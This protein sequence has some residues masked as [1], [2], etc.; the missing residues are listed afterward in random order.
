MNEFFLYLLSSNFHALIF[1][2]F[3][4]TCIDLYDQ[5]SDI[6][7]FCLDLFIIITNCWKIYCKGHTLERKRNDRTCWVKTTNYAFGV[8]AATR[9]PVD[10]HVSSPVNPV[11]W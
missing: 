5:M 9:V 6:I 7:V 10:I 3:W 11:W 1:F 4:P 2:K 8:P